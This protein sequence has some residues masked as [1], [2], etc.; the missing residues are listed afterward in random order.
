MTERGAELIWL[1]L[2]AYA[3]IG[4][5]VSLALLLGGLRRIDAAMAA[6]PLRV[7]ALIAPGIV[8]LWPLLLLRYFGVKPREDRL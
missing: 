4:V 1:C 3:A 6:A 8:M 5:L 2:G 7:K